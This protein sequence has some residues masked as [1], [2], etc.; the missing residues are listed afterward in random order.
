MVNT[1]Q[2]NERAFLVQ[3]LG[4]LALA[5]DSLMDLRAKFYAGNVNGTINLMK[6]ARPLF[7][8]RWYTYDDVIGGDTTVT[9]AAGS[10]TIA[11]FTVPVTT[12]FQKIALETTAAVAGSTAE[13]VLYS[14]DGNNTFT[15]LLQQTL[16]TDAVAVASA[17]ISLTLNPGLYWLGA[18]LLSPTTIATVRARTIAPKIGTATAGNDNTAAVGINGL[19]SAASVPASF[20][21]ATSQTSTL[22]KVMLQRT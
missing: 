15:K 1:L 13:A 14:Y 3:A 18:V 7:P 10:L 12:T 22:P 20:A 19:T 4:A 2:D 5:T 17:N 9:P 16:L 11:P 8:A 21:L 6:T